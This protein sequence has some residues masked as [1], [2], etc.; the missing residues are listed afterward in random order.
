[1]RD[2]TLVFVHG[3]SVTNLDTYGELPARLRAEAAS[4]GI[5]IIVENIYLGQYISFHDEVRLPDISRAFQMAIKDKLGAAIA[6]GMRFVAITHSTGGPVVR[7][8][9]NRFKDQWEQ[10]P[11]SHLIML[12]PANF[13]S[14]LA[15]LGKSRLSRIVGLFQGVEPGQG[16][17]DWLELG[18][19]ESWALNKAW[20][21]SDG[22]QINEQN[23]FPFALI[24]Q[25]IDRKFYDNLNSYTGELGSDGVVRSAAANLN[26]HYVLLKQTLPSEA[27]GDLVE[28][29]KVAPKTPFLIVR[30]TAHS[31]PDMGIMAAEKAEIGHPTGA[32]TVNAILRCINV[33]NRADYDQLCID[34]D[35]E[36][37][38]V[39]LE[40]RLEI[41]EK[42]LFARSK[43]YFIHDRFSM[44]IFRVTDSEGL[45][46]RDFDLTFTSKSNHDMSQ[47]DDPNY[48]PEGFFADRQRNSRNPETVT[49]FVNHDIMT[50]TP[51]VMDGSKEVRPELD[52]ISVLGLKV[53]PRPDQG[54]VRYY[55]FVQDATAEFFQ[56]VVNPNSTTLIEV[57]LQRLVDKNVFVINGPQD[58]F[59]FAK[60]FK[61]IGTSDEIAE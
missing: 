11:M 4:S 53:V 40:E 22:S 32:D 36:T 33:S 20:I 58:T 48:L 55:P 47:P 28:G 24:G 43:R 19:S 39:Q 23:Y 46:V 30:N 29:I 3:Y 15:Q 5:N 38:A 2:I 59:P 35:N 44:I 51:A 8:W 13:G 18:S 42:G 54:F 9:S 61:K 1:M 57:R 6:A 27:D 50:A 60:D 21:E 37:Q 56:T 45:P 31:G 49:Y 16:V 17:L 25:S 34:F 26:A 14:A 41:V 12:A 7:D 10:L 52:G